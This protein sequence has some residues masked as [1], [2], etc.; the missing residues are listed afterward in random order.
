MCHYERIG[1]QFQSHDYPQAPGSYIGG[2]AQNGGGMSTL[3]SL[4]LMSSQG[5]NGPLSPGPDGNGP[6]DNAGAFSQ[7][8]PPMA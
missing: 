3:Q 1:H 7:Q 2:G 4:G 5:A 6:R 8:L